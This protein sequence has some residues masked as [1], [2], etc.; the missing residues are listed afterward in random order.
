MPKKFKNFKKVHLPRTS[1]AKKFKKKKFKEIHAPAA[2]E[3]P[4][5]PQSL[6]SAIMYHVDALDELDI[7]VQ[8]K[9]WHSLGWTPI[10]E[11]ASW[12][13]EPH[14]R[15]KAMA[16]AYKAGSDFIKRENLRQW[17]EEAIDVAKEA[18]YMFKGEGPFVSTECEISVVPWSD[19]AKDFS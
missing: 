17:T 11:P 7:P 3:D 6:T 14:I 13:P 12:H 10:P 2:T 19:F 1:H 15:Y 5:G 16:A 9:H 18:A 8:D 4:K